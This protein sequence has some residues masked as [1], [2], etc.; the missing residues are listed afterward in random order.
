MSHTCMECEPTAAAVA[1]HTGAAAVQNE[2]G[3]LQLRG[4]FATAFTGGG[5]TATETFSKKSGKTQCG[6]LDASVTSAIVFSFPG[7]TRSSCVLLEVSCRD[8]H[9]SGLVDC[10][11]RLFFDMV[12]LIVCLS[13]SQSV[14]VCLSDC[15][16]LVQCVSVSVSL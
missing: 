13:V 16:C 3:R 2:T 6:L 14:S 1:G 5:N 12:C 8:L 11:S 15:L 4:L 7:F 9:L 10:R